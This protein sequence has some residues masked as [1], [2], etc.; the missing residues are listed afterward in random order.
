MHVHTVL[1]QSKP[2]EPG[3]KLHWLAVH[4]RD[5]PPE[6]GTKLARSRQKLVTAGA[7]LFP[8]PELEVS[9]SDTRPLLARPRVPYSNLRPTLRVLHI[10]VTLS[11]TCWNVGLLSEQLYA[12]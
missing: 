3:E 8:E 2:A 10:K 11:R 1:L 4:T 12:L 7:E 6:T 5:W 9:W